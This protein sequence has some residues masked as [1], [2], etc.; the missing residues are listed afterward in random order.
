MQKFWTRWLL[1]AVLLIVGCDGCRRPDSEKDADEKVPVQDF[2]SL[3]PD[4]FPADDQATRGSVKPGHWT[5][6]SY[7]LKSNKADSRGQLTSR[8]QMIGDTA[9]DSFDASQLPSLRPIV[10]PKGQKR[11]FDYRLL[12]PVPFSDETSQIRLSNRY[13]SAGQGT[14]YEAPPQSFELM[15]PEEYYFVVLTSRPQRYTRL[16][17]ANWAES[18][19]SSMG[20]VGR[21]GN[22]R[23]MIPP[24]GGVMPLSETMLDWTSTAVVWWDNLS[25]DALTPSQQLALADWVNFGGTLVVNGP[26]AAESI[27]QSSFAKILALRPT[28][29]I[30][31]DPSAGK[32]LLQSWAVETD[33]ST[34]KQIA[35]LGGAAAR[36]AV[37]G[38]NAV[39]ATEVEGSG[40]LILTRRQGLGRVV[41][42]RFDLMEDWLSS[43]SSYD[44]FINGVI[45]G[46]PRRAFRNSAD[47]LLSDSA[48]KLYP[49][50]GSRAVGADLN[51]RLRIT[52]RDAILPI[53]TANDSQNKNRSESKAK[54]MRSFDRLAFGSTQA[55]IGGWNDQSDVLDLCTDV[56]ANESAI[57]VPEMS[58]VMKSLG[59]YLLVLVPL[60]YIVFRL[61]GRL[62]YAWLAVPVIAIGGTIAISRAVRLDIGFARSQTEL[63]LLEMQYRF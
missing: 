40:N 35:T 9:A 34:D 39:D 13:T 28:S 33:R 52:S 58:L 55:G 4:I 14:Y 31:L 48:S 7:E 16:R 36:V 26:D 18:S 56:V 57:E 3:P 1:G 38:R 50:L 32:T 2:T 17:K 15:A 12:V 21:G 49:D 46:R 19:R 5:S 44:S 27:N 10:L 43:W 11:R 22:Y 47:P 42:A 63:S 51:T 23:I 41:Q 61:M 8:F 54:G 25:P 45:L 62:E 20:F 60:N 6:A 30:E 29:N 59:L 37:D 24:A 53:A